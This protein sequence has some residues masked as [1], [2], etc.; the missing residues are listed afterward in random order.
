METLGPSG[1]TQE[2]K[3]SGS[4][5]K[6]GHGMALFQGILF[7]LATS[8]NGGGGFSPPAPTHLSQSKGCRETCLTVGSNLQKHTSTRTHPLDATEKPTVACLKPALS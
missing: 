5:R 3:G 2:G 7:I 1:K 8:G 6:E 4:P